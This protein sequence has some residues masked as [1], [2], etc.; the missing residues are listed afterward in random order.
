MGEWSW[1][2]QNGSKPELVEKT[3]PTAVGLIGE[4][5]S[6]IEPYFCEDCFR[7]NMEILHAW[8]I[9]NISQINAMGVNLNE[10]D[11]QDSILQANCIN[12]E[13]EII[14]YSPTGGILGCT[15]NPVWR[16][17]LLEVA[18][19]S[20]TL[21]EGTDG[22]YIDDWQGTLQIL[23]ANYPND[24]CF[25]QYCMQGFREYLRANYNTE[26]LRGFGIE[27]IDSFDY[28][29]YIRANYLTLYKD[30]CWEVPLYWDF[31]DYQM[32]SII[33]FSHQ[34][35]KE[36]KA[37]AIG[38]GK[39][40]VFS[41]NTCQ[42]WS[43]SIP[44]AYDLD[45]FSPEYTY[46][47]PPD[48][49]HI[50][51]YKLG[52]SLGTP[53]LTIPQSSSS[54]ISDIMTRPDAT[55]LWKIYTAEAYSAGGFA[56][57]PYG[58]PIF[59]IENPINFDGNIDDLAPYYDFISTNKPYY[60]NLVSAGRMAVFYSYPSGRWMYDSFENDFYGICNLLLDAHFQHD[61]IFSG[62]DD[63]ME[64]K[65]TLSALQRYEVV[66]LPD[67]K[68]L[69]DRQVNLLL[70][71]VNLG[72][73]I[74][75]FGGIGSHNEKGNYVERPELES[76]LTEGSHSYGSGN[77]VY[78]SSEVG[79]QYLENRNASV[80]LQFAEAL[81]KLIY[82]NIQTNA[83]ENVAILE[84][85]NN[86]SQS[87]VL[88]VINYDYDLEEQKINSQKNIDL[89]LLIY[90][91]LS[92]KNLAILYRSPDWKGVERLKYESNGN[93]IKLTIPKVDFYG[94]VTIGQKGSVIPAIMLLLLDDQDETP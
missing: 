36:V 86:V 56:L 5:A 75:A 64:D 55:N 15:N 94:V 63:W 47:Y 45:Y 19:R 90:D 50:P 93:K 81:K 77:F 65:L 84:Y 18:K 9:K 66:V 38:Q 85:W 60:E 25:C 48:S 72:G 69:S 35:I 27:N 3:H 70:S 30:N 54:Q 62:D 43:G 42:M 1:Y 24:G 79:Y 78:M 14:R 8:G 4:S 11:P 28:G 57:E 39:K 74:I 89:E 51:T 83:S 23:G 80:R 20:I 40:V 88:H 59:W 61:V 44:T 22:I 92:G 6:G 10:I 21:G 13:G 29:D 17:H 87:I 68:H 12:I 82:P 16:E 71:Y 33:Q 53:V 73:N 26:E 46:G 31:Y 41:A 76:L 7:G 91:P 32:E 52:T 49:R 67:T 34:Y 2:Y 37:F 58:Y